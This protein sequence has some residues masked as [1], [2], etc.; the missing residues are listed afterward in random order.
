MYDSE[1]APIVFKQLVPTREN[2]DPVQ[3]AL[4]ICS[5]GYSFLCN[6]LEYTSTQVIPESYEDFRNIMLESPIS[7]GNPNHANTDED[8]IPSSFYTLRDTMIETYFEGLNRLEISESE[9]LLVEEL[10]IEEFPANW[11]KFRKKLLLAFFC[12]NDS[13]DWIM[14]MVSSNREASL[15]LGLERV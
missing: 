13:I 2:L 8:K 5:F 12:R 10:I 9:K 14:Q 6:G 1:G 3:R 7:F 15:S 4:N 11:E